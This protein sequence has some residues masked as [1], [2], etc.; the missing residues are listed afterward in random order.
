MKELVK[1]IREANRRG[2]KILICGNGGLAAEAE[3]FASELVGKYGGDNFVPCLSLTCNS[4]LLTATANDFGFEQSFSHLVKVLGKAN[5]ILIA[6][7]TTQ[8][9]N[10]VASI[11]EAKR[12]GM[13]TVCLCGADSKIEAEYLI[14]IPHSDSVLIQQAILAVLHEVATGV[15]K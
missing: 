7:T 6:M 1:L 9:P 3:H 8:S 14:R 4:S 11:K 10:I 2:N 15:K 13:V 12:K 5:D